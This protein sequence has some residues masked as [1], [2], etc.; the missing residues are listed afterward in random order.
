MEEKDRIFLDKSLIKKVS[1]VVQMLIFYGIQNE[2]PYLTIREMVVFFS[3]PNILRDDELIEIVHELDK[4]GLLVQVKT[5]NQDIG[6]FI[7]NDEVIG[8]NQ[9]KR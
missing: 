7:L 8:K 6:Y 4:C 9:Q 5:I 3:Q 2:K 1:Y